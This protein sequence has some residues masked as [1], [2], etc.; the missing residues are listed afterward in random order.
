MV[1]SPMMRITLPFQFTFQFSDILVAIVSTILLIYGGKPFYQGAID[2][3]KQKAP[4]MMALVS[5][6]VGV[7]YLYSIYAVITHYTTGRS[8][9]RRVGKE[10]RAQRG[11]MVCN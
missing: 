6:G 8:E 1:L 5:L 2:E 4:G 10:C 9:E 7:S 11:R 3:F